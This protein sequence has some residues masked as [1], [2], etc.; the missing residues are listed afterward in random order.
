MVKNIFEIGGGGG[1]F[2]YMPLV[3]H[4]LKEISAFFSG[5]AH[6]YDYHR[7]EQTMEAA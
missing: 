4:Y 7:S 2:S 3:P 1:V 5:V 6:Y